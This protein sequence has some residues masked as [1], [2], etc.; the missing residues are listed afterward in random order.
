VNVT[1]PVA[2][3]AA[4]SRTSFIDPVGRLVPIGRAPGRLRPGHT[5]PPPASLTRRSSSPRDTRSGV[6]D[7]FR[8]PSVHAHIYYQNRRRRRISRTPALY[9][10][11]GFPKT[12][13]SN[14][15]SVIR[16]YNPCPAPTTS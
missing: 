6:I 11:D 3:A 16:P 5:S 1:P 9:Y 15:L 2:T 8:P 4:A 14:S 12:I 10:Y 13:F 7:V